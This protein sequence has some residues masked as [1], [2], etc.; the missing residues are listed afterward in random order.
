[1]GFQAPRFRR[2]LG[3]SKGAA[4]AEFVLWLGLLIIPMASA[5][6][7]GIYA[8]QKMQVEMAS[9]AAV[10][11]AWK[12]CDTAGKLPATK[13]ATNCGADLTT[14]ITTAAQSTS[15]GTGVTIASGSPVEGYY[16]TAADNTLQLVGATG[17]IGS[18]PTK[19]SPFTCA[20]VVAGSTIAPG[21]Y[22]QV[23]V[24]YSYAP[25]FSGVSIAEL[26]T[27]PITKTAWTRLG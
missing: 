14:T 3:D 2:F 25:V 20:T 19:P 5:V 11:A 12:A 7:V 1:M 21:D 18:P 17:V 24:S 8:F 26:L 6:D 4:A 15:L 13:T 22:L 27:T 9:Q 10:Q 23:T 16:C